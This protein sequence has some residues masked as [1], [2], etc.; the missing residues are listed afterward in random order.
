MQWTTATDSRHAVAV[1]ASR[2]SDEVLIRAP[3]DPGRWLVFPGA[4]W[5]AFF[6]ALRAGTFDDVGSAP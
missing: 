4:E 2:T 3:G 6:Q 5:R 1:T